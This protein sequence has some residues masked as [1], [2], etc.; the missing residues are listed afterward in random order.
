[1][2][3]DVDLTVAQ[4]FISLVLVA[5]WGCSMMWMGGLYFRDGSRPMLLVA[6]LVAAVVAVLLWRFKMKVGAISLMVGCLGG[7]IALVW[8]LIVSMK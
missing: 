2:S 6:T 3:D 8:L 5:V 4:G 7:P 1:M